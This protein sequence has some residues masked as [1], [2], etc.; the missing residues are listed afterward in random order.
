MAAKESRLSALHTMQ[1]E[2]YIKMLEKGGTVV[3]QDEDG[4][5]IIQPLT[6]AALQAI[7]K[8]L[9]DNDITCAPDDA[10][11]VGELETRMR[12][13]T[14]RR[15]ERRQQRAISQA[16]LAEAGGAFMGGVDPLRMQ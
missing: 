15:E 16:E 2:Y 12:D 6:P 9:K 5:D 13:R 7:N 1:A 4:E 8:F 14:S 11:A 10:N 3:G